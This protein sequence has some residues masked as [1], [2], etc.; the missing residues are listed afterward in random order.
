MLVIYFLNNFYHFWNF[1]LIFLLVLH[2][3][4]SLY[5]FTLIR[6]ILD[7]FIL[8]S[9]SLSFAHIF[10]LFLFPTTFNLFQAYYFSALL[11]LFFCLTSWLS[12][13]FSGNVF[14]FWKFYFVVFFKYATYFNGIVPSCNLSTTVLTLYI[15]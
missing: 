14:H 3:I 11:C 13:M 10:N 9:K 7:L 5:S 6:Y 15:L 1:K 8:F 4:H 12:F 2:L